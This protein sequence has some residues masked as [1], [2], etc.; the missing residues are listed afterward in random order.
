MFQRSPECTER[1]GKGYTPVRSVR[2]LV[3]MSAVTFLRPVVTSEPRLRA[4]MSSAWL[5]PLAFG[6]CLAASSKNWPGFGGGGGGGGPALPA[7]CQNGHDHARPIQSPKNARSYY[8][9]TKSDKCN[10]HQRHRER[11]VLAGRLVKPEAP[12]ATKERTW[13]GR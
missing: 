2:F 1:S 12:G 5:P 9:G 4:A 8:K 6:F 3:F 7:A 10:R 11:T 13:L